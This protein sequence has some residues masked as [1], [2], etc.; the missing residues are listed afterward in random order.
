V[1]IA[2]NFFKENTQMKTITLAFLCLALCLC[3]FAQTAS[4]PTPQ[5]AP[6]QPTSAFTDTTVSFGLTPVTLPSRVNTLAG[7][8]TDILLNVS[9]NNVLGETSLISSSPFIGGRYIRL[10]PSVS[11][12]I[13]NHSS[14]TGG[15]F[16]AGLT[17]SLGVVKADAPHYGE[18]AGFVLNYA[19]AGNKTFGLG[20]DVEANNLPG[21]AHWIPSI[22]IAPTFHF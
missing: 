13:Q 19:P 21:V 12:W 15:Q 1:G 8:E 9:A 10:F 14:F 4:T 6:T 7:A 20:L 17:V 18:R 22:A 11:K 2:K 5:P 16:Q 3:G